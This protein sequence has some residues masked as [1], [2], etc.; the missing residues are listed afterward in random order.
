MDRAAR[1]QAR[2]NNT[3][4]ASAA[5]TLADPSQDPNLPYQP[6][7]PYVA[8]HK[9][10]ADG[11][12]D[13]YHEEWV[14][15][16]RREADDIYDYSQP[17]NRPPHQWTGDEDDAYFALLRGGD[18]FGSQGGIDFKRVAAQLNFDVDWQQCK[19]RWYGFLIDTTDGSEAG[20]LQCC[21]RGPRAFGRGSP[22]VAGV[23][24]RLRRL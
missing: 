5:G 9:A 12:R 11:Q 16:A 15:R 6:T 14:A 3:A 17:S 4:A 8:G 24:W 23:A 20:G 18:C 21:E 19:S 13:A 10:D 7:A 1:R 22:V 2:L